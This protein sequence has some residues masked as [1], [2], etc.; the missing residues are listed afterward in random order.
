MVT[1]L[2]VDFAFDRL[3]LGLKGSNIDKGLT[4][5]DLLKIAVRETGK[6]LAAEEY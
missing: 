1:Q 2:D 5:S 3:R 4:E 6:V